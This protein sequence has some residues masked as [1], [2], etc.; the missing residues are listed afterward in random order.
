MDGVDDIV[1]G[2]EIAVVQWSTVELMAIE[3]VRRW[4]CHRLKED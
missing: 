1:D 3:R 4:E 2:V